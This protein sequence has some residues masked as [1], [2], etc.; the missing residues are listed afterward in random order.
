MTT[1]LPKSE[2]GIAERCMQDIKKVK[3]LT[4]GISNEGVFSKASV[5]SYSCR[6]V[7]GYSNDS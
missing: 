1:V 4:I 7:S 6:E 3:A 5:D 2:I